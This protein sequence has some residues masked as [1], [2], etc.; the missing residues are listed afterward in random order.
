MR[1]SPSKLRG[2]HPVHAVVPV[3]AA[4]VFSGWVWF[5]DRGPL[6]DSARLAVTAMKPVEGAAAAPA[7]L[8][9]EVC[10][11]VPTERTL[12]LWPRGA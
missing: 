1:S 11:G 12:H 7:D 2:P 5:A 6:A 8:P 3:L 4:I 9:I 10:Y